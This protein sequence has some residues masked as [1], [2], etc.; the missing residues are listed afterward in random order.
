MNP[1]PSLPLRILGNARSWTHCISA[2]AILLIANGCADTEE[3]TAE[4]LSIA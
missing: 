4:G 1:L 2:A 3:S